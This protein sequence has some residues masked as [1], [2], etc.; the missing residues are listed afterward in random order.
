VV[1]RVAKV[2]MAFFIV[3]ECGSQAVREGWLM[4]VVQIQYFGFGLRGETTG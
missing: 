2:E 4:A 1:R 3:V